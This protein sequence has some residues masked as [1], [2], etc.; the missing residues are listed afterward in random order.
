MLIY[1]A[2]PYSAPIVEE[3]ENNVER[4]M[5][6]GQDII[7]RGHWPVIPHL[8]HWFDL[9]TQQALTY[10]QYIAWGLALLR[11]CDALL[12]LGSSP[13]AERERSLALELGIPI[14]GRVGEIP[15]PIR[16]GAQDAHG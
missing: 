8:S 2:G 6:A 15:E 7:E 5:D 4:A 3:R 10:A 11:R 9:Y 16:M 13:G 1:V 12:F 14:F